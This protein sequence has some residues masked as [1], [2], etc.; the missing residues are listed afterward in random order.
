MPNVQTP[1]TIKSDMH[2]QSIPAPICLYL[3]QRACRSVALSAEDHLYRSTVDSLKHQALSHFCQSWAGFNLASVLSRGIFRSRPQ[4]FSC[5]AC[6][7][8]DHVVNID[9]V[10]LL[11]PDVH[12][13]TNYQMGCVG[14]DAG[15]RIIGVDQAPIL[16]G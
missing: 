5:S 3:L 7:W 16:H 14:R 2:M 9:I 6:S 8:P 4:D 15:Q 11:G 13:T 1:R 12:L 10:G